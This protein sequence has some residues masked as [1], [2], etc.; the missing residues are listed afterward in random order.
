M[1]KGRRDVE[2]VVRARNEASKAVGAITTSLDALTKSQK[3]AS[4]SAGKTQSTLSQLG[5]EL[6]KLGAQ[7]GGASVFEKLAASSK[8]AADAVAQM[9][10]RAGEAALEQ[11]RL[12][13]QVAKTEAE[14]NT[15]AKAVG[16]ANANLRK[17]KADT[18]AAKQAQADYNA[19]LRKAKAAHEAAAAA[20]E[21]DLAKLREQQK[22][23]QS[24]SRQGPSNELGRQQTR[25]SSLQDEEIGSRL[26]K[27]L[28][29]N[30]VAELESQF[31]GLEMALG[32]VA[33]AES[34]AE[35]ELTDL[36]TK[37][38]LA[39][40]NLAAL[41]NAEVASSNAAE[42]LAQG[43]SEAKAALAGVQASTAS[44]DSTIWSRGRSRAS[45]I[46][47]ATAWLDS[48]AARMPSLWAS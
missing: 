8:R 27:S 7:I 36:T 34:R 47:W 17:A 33:S 15:L 25:L 46:A 24:L 14:Y 48:S 12:A 26:S 23:V 18:A 42:R 30:R 13:A 5:A 10:D 20:H 6:G 2:L 3:N 44:A 16:T 32:R 29:G 41:R 35:K 11:S 43:L 21:K 45:L 38:G 4:A 1:A 31:L 39:S 19:E 40:T 9:S 22:L 28:A 37:M